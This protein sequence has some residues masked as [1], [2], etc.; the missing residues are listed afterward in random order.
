MQLHGQRAG[1]PQERRHRR[2][3]FTL[4]ELAVVMA[5]IGVII[6]SPGPAHGSIPRSPLAPHK[7]TL[8]RPTRRLPSV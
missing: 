3:G 8:A 4:M 6:S 5:I 7:H 1:A 2:R